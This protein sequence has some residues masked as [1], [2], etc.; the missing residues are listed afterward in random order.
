MSFVYIMSGAD[1]LH[2]IGIADNP[3]WRKNGVSVQYPHR[4]PIKIVRRYWV[5]KV[6]A[7]E[8]ETAVHR[9]LKHK[10]RDGEWF[11]ASL[12]LC[13]STICHELRRRGIRPM[14]D[15]KWTKEPGLREYNALRDAEEAY[16]DGIM[17]RRVGWMPS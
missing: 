12:Q 15:R 2:K 7:Q 10:R 11:E 8:I 5:Y 6:P 1:G 13:V 17:W 9:I 3:D 14:K 4:R 16:T